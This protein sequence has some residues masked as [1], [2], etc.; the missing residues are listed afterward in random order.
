MNS[1]WLVQ[2]KIQGLVIFRYVQNSYR[3]VER[4]WGSTTDRPYNNLQTQ[5]T[6]GK[7]EELCV[8]LPCEEN[9]TSYLASSHLFLIVLQPFTLPTIKPTG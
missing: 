8:P 2:S 6:L 5:L 1:I 3:E 4:G 7:L 9:K